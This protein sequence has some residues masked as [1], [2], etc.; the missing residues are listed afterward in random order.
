MWT[1]NSSM[2]SAEEKAEIPNAESRSEYAT[3]C[4]GEEKKTNDPMDNNR[5]HRIADKSGSQ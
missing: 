1:S 2:T 5:L 3:A 4:S